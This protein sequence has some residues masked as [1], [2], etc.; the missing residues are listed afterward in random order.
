MTEEVPVSQFAAR[1]F[2]LNYWG[3]WVRADIPLQCGE[4]M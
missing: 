4:G 1:C 2:S 3:K